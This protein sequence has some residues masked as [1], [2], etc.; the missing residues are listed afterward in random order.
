MRQT[1]KRLVDERGRVQRPDLAFP[2]QVS[3]RQFLQLIVNERNHCMESLLIA[4]MNTL[5]QF[6]DLH[7]R[8]HI[9]A[10]PTEGV[11]NFPCV[12]GSRQLRIPGASCPVRTTYSE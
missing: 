6:R 12:S 3:R 8:C 5:Q 7:G 2:P 9:T 4:C 1:Q 10:G 11:R